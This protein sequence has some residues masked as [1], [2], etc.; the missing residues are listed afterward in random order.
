[1]RDAFENGPSEMSG[2]HWTPDEQDEIDE[3]TVFISHD[4]VTQNNFGLAKLPMHPESVKRMQAGFEPIIKADRQ[5]VAR[6]AR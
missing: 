3:R 4:F 2:L 1:M 5:W 6:T